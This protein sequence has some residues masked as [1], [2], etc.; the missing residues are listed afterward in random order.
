MPVPDKPIPRQSR[1]TTKSILTVFLFALATLAMVEI[2]VRQIAPDPRL[3]E[4]SDGLRDLAASDPYT[5]VI[6]SSHARTFHVLGQVLAQRTGQTMPLVAVPLELGKLEPYRWLLEHRV[7]PLIDGPDGG[8][9]P[10]HGRLRRLILLTE[11]WDSC[12]HPDKR[13]PNLPSRA[14]DWP[15]YRDDVLAEGV[16]SFNRDYLRRR[17]REW[18]GF[19]RL[20]LDRSFPGIRAHLLARARGLDAP[21]GRS[22]AEEASFLAGW[23]EMTDDGA[24]CQ[25]ADQQMRALQAIIEFARQRG[26]EMHLVLFPRRPA[27]VTPFAREHTFPLFRARIEQAIAGRGIRLHDLSFS[28]PLGDDDFMADYDHVNAEGNRKF[29]DWA[30]AGPFAFLLG[31]ED[32]TPHQ[33]VQRRSH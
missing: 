1:A 8:R 21:A 33:P 12:D 9:A 31:P 29:A 11:W 16:T 13:H 7:A 2:G 18:L 15:T 6:G 10:G 4:V 26:L 30:L 28:T 32:A 24:H 20:V 23:R 27:T 14:W 22:E 19:S 3:R 5:L 25:G 17:L